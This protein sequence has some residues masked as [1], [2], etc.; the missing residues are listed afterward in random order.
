[1]YIYKPQT[2]RSISGE[3]YIICKHYNVNSTVQIEKL[4]NIYNNFLLN[5]SIYDYTKEFKKKIL[6]ICNE[7]FI[8]NNKL[9]ENMIFQEMNIYENKKNENKIN[10]NKINENKNNENI[11]KVWIKKYNFKFM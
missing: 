4:I 11:I 10:E 7:I 3:F 1:M 8:Y 2:S 5:Q 6:H 9:V